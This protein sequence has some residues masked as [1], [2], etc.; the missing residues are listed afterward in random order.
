MH[1]EFKRVKHGHLPG[2]VSKKR[3][4]QMRET[5]GPVFIR[6]SSS[7]AHII[8]EAACKQFRKGLAEKSKKVQRRRNKKACQEE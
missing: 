3:L 6:Y 1:N 7:Y 2:D 4:I 5:R 8:G